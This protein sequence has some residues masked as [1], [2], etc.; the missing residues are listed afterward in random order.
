MLSQERRWRKV[1]RCKETTASAPQQDLRRGSLERI[2]KWIA[3]QNTSVLATAAITALASVPL[4]AMADQ[5]KVAPER[6]ELRCMEQTANQVA[7]GA[8]GQVNY[9]QAPPAHP[10]PVLLTLIKTDPDGTHEIEPARIESN[11]PWLE[12]ER[13]I[14]SRENQVTAD[15]GRLRVNLVDNRLYL[16]EAPTAENAHFRR[17]TC[18]RLTPPSANQSTTDAVTTNPERQQPPAGGSALNGSVN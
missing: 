14:W 13:A 10:D 8:D 17:F 1:R 3:K 18:E 16:T 9:S 11:V 6:I 4:P 5:P 7:F 15:Q 12:R 2:A